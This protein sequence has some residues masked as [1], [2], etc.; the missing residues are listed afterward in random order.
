M[1]CTAFTYYIT[2]MAKRT[3][4]WLH[5]PL[6]LLPSV[7]LQCTDSRCVLGLQFANTAATKIA[8]KQVWVTDWK[9]IHHVTNFMVEQ[10]D[11]HLFLPIIYQ[12]SCFFVQTNYYKQAPN[13][14]HNSILSV[15]TQINTCTASHS[16]QSS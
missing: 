3:C 8:N 11:L 15:W 16:K 2:L 5:H 6:H 14:K 10:I 13:N 7:L 1:D 9:I 4:A 12:Y